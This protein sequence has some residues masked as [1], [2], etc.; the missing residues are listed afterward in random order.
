M[1]PNHK[2]TKIHQMLCSF[3][4]DLMYAQRLGDLVFCWQAV[5]FRKNLI[6]K[7][8]HFQIKLSYYAFK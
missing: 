5:N 2:N 7:L 8:Y 3:I 6:F 4:G 1:P